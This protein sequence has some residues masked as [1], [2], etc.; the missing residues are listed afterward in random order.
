MVQTPNSKCDCSSAPNF[1]LA[2]SEGYDL[3]TPRACYAVRRMGGREADDYLVVTV[4]P[5]LMGQRYGLGDKDIDTVVL[6]TRHGGSTLFPVSEWPLAV[7]VA[8]IL[9]ERDIEGRFEKGDLELIGWGELYRTEAEA[10]Q[11]ST[12]R[13]VRRAERQ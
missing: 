10:A 7:H 6:A 2:S 12:R 4:S 3:E 1:Y 8:R 5:P 11:P 9:H 13:P